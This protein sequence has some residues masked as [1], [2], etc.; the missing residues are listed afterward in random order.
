MRRIVTRAAA[1]AVVGV[2]GVGGVA[3]ATPSAGFGNGNVG[4]GGSGATY[5]GGG[6]QGAGGGGQEQLPA[7]G[8]SVSDVV[9]EHLA[10]MVQEEK[11]ARDVYAL[12]ESLYSDRVFVN[13]GQSESTHVAAVQSLLDRYGIADPTVGLAAGEFV[14]TGLT[15]LYEQLSAQVRQSRDGAIDAGVSIEI[16]DIADLR[17]ALE[18]DAPAD[19]T[20]VLGNLLE[21]SQRHLAA[22]QRQA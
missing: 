1:L 17:A 18:L 2:V 13:I 16:K 11:L 10:F 7:A 21:A 14:D 15:D 22:F 19:V 3:A 9:A 4:G 12:A 8:A 20:T 5:G 6:A